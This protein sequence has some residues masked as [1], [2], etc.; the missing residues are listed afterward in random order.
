MKLIIKTLVNGLKGKIH[1]MHVV[2]GIREIR[3]IKAA[4]QKDLAEYKHN[5]S[6]WNR[7][8]MDTIEIIQE[9][10]I[11]LETIREEIKNG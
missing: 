7:R 1:Q 10:D 11:C 9:Y 5:R 8:I 6:Y 2:L 4:H 3:K